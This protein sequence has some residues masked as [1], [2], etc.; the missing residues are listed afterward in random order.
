MPIPRHYTLTFGDVCVV[1]VK[2]LCLRGGFQPEVSCSVPGHGCL[3]KYKYPAA[4]FS[5]RRSSNFRG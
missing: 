1:L 5:L 3:I 4:V 2:G